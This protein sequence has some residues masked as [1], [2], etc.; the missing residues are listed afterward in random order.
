MSNYGDQNDFYNDLPENELEFI[1]AKFYSNYPKDV[2]Q[3]KIIPITHNKDDLRDGYYVFIFEMLIQFYLEGLCHY[4]KLQLIL[5]KSKM[6]FDGNILNELIKNNVYDDIDYKKIN[7]N[8][9]MLPEEWFKSIGFYI[10]IYEDEY[11]YYLDLQK[12]KEI[13]K[14]SIFFNHYCKILLRANPQDESLFVFK[15]IEKPYHF[16]INGEFINNKINKIDD[17]HS[18]LIMNKKIYRISFSEI[19]IN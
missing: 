9:L 2:G 1:V 15:N 17:I 19:K 12:D 14:N 6:D 5:N 8:F 18:I 11:D 10:N 13:Y 4:Q 16:F 7:N 3:N